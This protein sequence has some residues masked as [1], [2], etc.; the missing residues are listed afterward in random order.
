ML[1]TYKGVET[2]PFFNYGM[3][4]EPVKAKDHYEVYRIELDGEELNYFEL[5]ILTR[6]MLVTPLT[7]YR[8]LEKLGFEDPIKGDIRKRFHGK[9][10]DETLQQ[11]I[12]QLANGPDRKVE[13]QEWLKRYLRRVRDCD[14]QRLRVSIDR[15]QYSDGKFVL[16]T[17]ESLF[18]L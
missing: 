13:F 15:Y 17:S 6:D 10:S 11:W 2:I 9:V 7:R 8:E 12:D 1:F 16:T 3:Y 18:E 5:P 4:S 14:S